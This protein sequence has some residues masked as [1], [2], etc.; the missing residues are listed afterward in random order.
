[1]RQAVNCVG[2]HLH[3][4]NALLLLILEYSVRNDWQGYS[5]S[6]VTGEHLGFNEDACV[7]EDAK[8]FSPDE[9]DD[10]GD[11]KNIT[12]AEVGVLPASPSSVAGSSWSPSACGRFASIFANTHLEEPRRQWSDAT[13]QEA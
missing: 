13:L 9:G 1:M 7:A 12:G 3:C 4:S 2:L 8:G 6:F 10:G 11:G 5:Y